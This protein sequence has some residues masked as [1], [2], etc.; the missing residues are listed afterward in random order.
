VGIQN[1]VLEAMAL[2]TPVVASSNVSA[3]LQAMAGRDL[4]VADDPETFASAV[5]RL[6]DDHALWNKLA[7]GGL[8]YVATFHNW[9]FILK[10]LNAVYARAMGKADTGETPI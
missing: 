10:Q 6:L 2:G 7:E 1:K 5:L 4:L 9:E 8:A 3:G